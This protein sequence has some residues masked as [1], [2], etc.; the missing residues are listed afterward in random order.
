[1]QPVRAEPK[2]AGVTP[3]VRFGE[4]PRAVPVQPVARRA[5]PCRAHEALLW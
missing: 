3:A 4:P 2:Q 5:A 1:M